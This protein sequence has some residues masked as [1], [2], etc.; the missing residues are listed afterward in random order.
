[1]PVELSGS[2]DGIAIAVM[3]FEHRLERAISRGEQTRDREG[4]AQAEQAMTEEELKTLHSRYRLDLSEHIEDC[5][6]KL[7]DHFPGFQFATIVG[8]EGWGAKISRDDLRLGERRQPTS[9][10]SR[11]EMLVRPYS[12]AHIV[13]LAAKGTIH[14]KEVLNRQHFQFLSQVDLDSFRELIDLWVLEYAEQYAART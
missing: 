10:Y 8:E 12:P 13:E 11:F 9:L 1:M 5:L 4:R 7:A 14:N 6:R 2:E 3:D